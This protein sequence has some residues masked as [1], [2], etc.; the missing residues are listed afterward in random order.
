MIDVRQTLDA[1]A[2]AHASRM[3]VSRVGDDAFEIELVIGNKL[4]KAP[5]FE[6][7]QMRGAI[8]WARDHGAG[9]TITFARWPVWLS[10]GAE[11]RAREVLRACD[12]KPARVTVSVSAPTTERGEEPMGGVDLRLEM[13]LAG[14]VRLETTID[15]AYTS[16]GEHDTV[17]ADFV[18]RGSA[19]AAALGVDCNAP[20]V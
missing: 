18:E 9:I 10:L 4:A 17:A 20:T 11:P 16:R 7:E 3:L 13:Q 14:D 19:L 5:I 6:L 15:T 2:H 1:L 12:A 8:R